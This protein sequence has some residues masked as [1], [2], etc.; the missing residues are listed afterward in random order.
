MEEPDTLQQEDR[1]R[2]ELRL[3]LFLIVF[4]FPLLTF[5]AVGGYGFLVWM[6]QLIMG[7]P[8]PPV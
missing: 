5:A 3:F 4:L 2:H 6:S 7:P 1:K 8:G